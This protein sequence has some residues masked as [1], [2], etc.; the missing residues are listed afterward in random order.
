MGSVDWK[1]CCYPLLGLGP[2]PLLLVGQLWTVGYLRGATGVRGRFSYVLFGWNRH[3]GVLVFE[4]YDLDP[5]YSGT[6][7]KRGCVSWI[8]VLDV[9]AKPR[10]SGVLFDTAGEWRG[11]TSSAWRIRSPGGRATDWPPSP[12]AASV[13][14]TSRPAEGEGRRRRPKRVSSRTGVSGRV[15]SVSGTKGVP[16]EGVTVITT[17]RYRRPTFRTK[18]GPS[19]ITLCGHLSSPRANPP[20]FSFPSEGLGT[21]STCLQELDTRILHS[22]KVSGWGKETVEWNASGSTGT[23]EILVIVDFEI[24]TFMGFPMGESVSTKLSWQRTCTRVE[25]S[26][27]L[28]IR[29]GGGRHRER[30]NVRCDQLTD[31]LPS[32]TGQVLDFSSGTCTYTEDVWVSRVVSFPCLTPLRRRRFPFVPGLLYVSTVIS[33]PCLLNLPLRP[34]YVGIRWTDVR[35]SSHSS[36]LNVKSVLPI[37]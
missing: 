34:C 27:G 33:L 22:F 31:Y 21:P 1:D 9:E 37:P 32:G 20:I 30:T 14:R 10:F 16:S 3:W 28:S 6:E 12:A 24:W 36:E 26:R 4:I 17:T 23:V 11:G 5:V 7:T 18:T 29:L 25:D 2:H 13:R 8:D 19:Q 35:L 15:S